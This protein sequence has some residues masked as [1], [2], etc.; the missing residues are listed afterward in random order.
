MFA[1]RALRFRLRQAV[2][3]PSWARYLPDELRSALHE[4]TE[5][6][7]ISDLGAQ[8]AANNQVDQVH[9]RPHSFESAWWFTRVWELSR[10]GE[11][12]REIQAALDSASC[13]DEIVAIASELHGRISEAV[14][15]PNANFVL[16]KLIEKL[17]PYAAVFIFQELLQ[18]GPESVAHVA[19]HKYGCRILQRLLCSGPEGHISVLVENLL[20][21]ADNAF[22]TCAHPFGNY[23]MQ[24]VLEVSSHS[25]RRLLVDILA[26]RASSAAPETHTLAVYV[27]AFASCERVERVKLARAVLNAPELL[28]KIKSSRQGHQAARHV[29]NSSTGA[30]HDRARVLLFGH[31]QRSATAAGA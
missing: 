18:K 1:A 20:H 6:S 13:E 10:N 3:T 29:L 16:Q 28:S 14:R 27:K 17:Q 12:C 30:E 5:S 2:E 24:K 8:P 26:D 21:D 23:V 7:D 19:R 9:L 11:G 22:D 15:C 25:S 31:R 4:R